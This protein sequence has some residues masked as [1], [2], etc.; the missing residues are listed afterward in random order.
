[1]SGASKVP[2]DLHYSKDHEWV[3]V[4][5]DS[6]RIGVTDFAQEQ[7]SDVV[8]VELPKPGTHLKQFDKFGIVESVKSVSELYAPVAGEVVQVNTELP[9][10]PELVNSDPYGKAWMIVVKPADLKADQT[11]LLTA[12]QYQHQIAAGH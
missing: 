2:A 7:L 11:K 4:E 9:K 1:M 6:V 8:Y 10:T 12:E 3:K 5:G